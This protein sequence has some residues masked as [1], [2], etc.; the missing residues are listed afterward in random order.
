ARYVGGLAELGL[1]RAPPPRLLQER[2]EQGMAI[3]LLDH[4]VRPS[5]LLLAGVLL[6]QEVSEPAL[7][8]LRP[9]AESGRDRLVQGRGEQTEHEEDD[10]NPDRDIQRCPIS[11]CSSPSCA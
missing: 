10:D 7:E 3:D 5:D 8:E 1:V 11:H 4:G 9:P 6:E 2:R